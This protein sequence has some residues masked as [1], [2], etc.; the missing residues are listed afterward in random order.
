MLG[1]SASSVY[2]GDF[3]KAFNPHPIPP[4]CQV[5]EIFFLLYYTA[6]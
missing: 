1:L 5:N 2:P 6:Q 4:N 3:E